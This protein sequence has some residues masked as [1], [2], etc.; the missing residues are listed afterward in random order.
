MLHQA[1]VATSPVPAAAL[2]RG[3]RGV[4]LSLAVL[5][6]CG[7]AGCSMLGPDGNARIFIDNG[8][9]EPM[10]VTVEGQEET[11]IA[12]GQF[13]KLTWSPGER[14]LHVRCGGRVLFD[15]TKTLE[16]R[17][18]LFNPDNQNR[19]LVYTVKYG[20]N[21]LAE[22]FQRG[23]AGDR[24][25]QIRAAYQKLA[26]E[27]E[28]LP[29][30]PWCEMPSVQYILEKPPEFVVTRAGSTEKRKVLTRIGHKDYALLKT[31]LAIEKPSED[32]LE[33]LADL[34]DRVSE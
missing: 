3:A 14:R 12:P 29:S 15:D 10:I 13:T 7:G 5:L 18:Y 9:T 26:K 25:A 2:P 8:S 28:L 11:T 27:V 24:Q 33:D 20:G 31:A 17:A 4:L 32:D 34:V 1:T 30:S 23:M 16:G 21:R 19:Y 22:L 6:A